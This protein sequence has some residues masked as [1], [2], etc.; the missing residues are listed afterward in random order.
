M[1]AEIL[2]VLVIAIVPL[3]ELLPIALPLVVAGTLSRW[4]RRR[5]WGDVVRGGGFHTAIGAAVGV[6]ALGAAVVV[7]TPVIEAVGQRGIEWSEHPIVRG[8]L[9]VAAIVVLQAAVTALAMELALRGWIVERTLELSPGPPVLP[10]FVGALVEALVTPGDL[11]ARFGA[12][13]FGVGLG[14]LYV[15]GGRSVTAPMTARIVFQVGI[16]VLEGLRVIG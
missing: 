3:P 10:I 15:A 4:L 9:T 12:G 5:S 7:G 1:P 8:N 13:L 14:W 11:A 16:V 2:A 6:V